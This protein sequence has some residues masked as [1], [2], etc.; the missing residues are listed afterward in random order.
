MY[1]CS[2][3]IIIFFQ[4]KIKDLKRSVRDFNTFLKKYN[5]IFISCSN[6]QQ[7]K[8]HINVISHL[9]SVSNHRLIDISEFKAKYKTAVDY[10]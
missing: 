5:Y 2:F 9:K 6:F 7:I 4:T 8:K 3:K 1:L 10:M